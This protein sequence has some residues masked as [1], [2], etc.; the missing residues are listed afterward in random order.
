MFCFAFS[1]LKDQW[2]RAKYERGEF[3]GENSHCQQ[4]YS[5]GDYPHP[6]LSVSKFFRTLHSFPC[7]ICC[8]VSPHLFYLFDATNTDVFESMLWKKGKDNKQFLKRVFLLSRKDFTL[9]YFIKEDVSSSFACSSFTLQCEMSTYQLIPSNASSKS[10]VPKA[11]I[12]MKD[13]NAVF[14]PEKISHAHGLQISYLH[15]ER[16]RNL[17]VYHENG[18]VSS[19]A[20]VFFCSTLWY[21]HVL[22]WQ[23]WHTK[24]ETSVFDLLILNLVSELRKMIWSRPSSI[25]VYL[26]GCS[27][28]APD[29]LFYI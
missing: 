8:L 15:D 27:L 10:K 23:T 19:G 24:P 22:T 7:L 17:F 2:I 29:V 20:V 3:T 14:Q 4:A 5:S 6:I 13:L 21:K 25:P 11:V 12:S 28:C 1:V 18:Q 26:R 9:R 16:M